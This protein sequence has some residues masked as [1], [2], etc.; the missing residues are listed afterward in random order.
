MS[1]ILKTLSLKEGLEWAEKKAKGSSPD[2]D[3][4]EF[5][6]L[7]LKMSAM[8][9]KNYLK[10]LP[11]WVRISEE[12]LTQAKLLTAYPNISFFRQVNQISPGSV[13][14]FDL[15]EL[16]T[17]DSHTTVPTSTEILAVCNLTIK[18]IAEMERN[19]GW[20]HRFMDEAHRELIRG[21]RAVIA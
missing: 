5:G 4:L 12:T 3:P 13:G 14:R 21:V 15:W 8:L 2:P 1:E 17:R 19:S 18:E 16:L 7:L 20:N 6:P 10:E 11:H 9:W